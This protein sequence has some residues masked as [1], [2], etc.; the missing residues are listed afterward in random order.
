[1][2]ELNSAL[3][4]LQIK[5]I[6]EVISRR[7]LIDAAYRNRLTEVKG[8]RCLGP[9]GETRQNFAYFP[10]LIGDAA[11]FS[12]DELNERLKARKIIGRRY[13]YPTI[14]EFPMYRGLASARPEN[15]PAARA[16][17]ARVFC[18]PIFPDLEMSIVDE[19]CDVI[20]HPGREA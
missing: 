17:A 3:G 19:I 8:V 1:M 2:S 10:I 13:F 18:L 12:R 9:S 14:S 4:L 16:A 7:G 20:C 15:L 11:P 6:D 5:Y